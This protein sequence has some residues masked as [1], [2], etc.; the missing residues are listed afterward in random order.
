M[1][2]AGGSAIRPRSLSAAS[3]AAPPAANAQPASAAEIGQSPGPRRRPPRDSGLRE[4]EEP[5][6]PPRWS[7][8]AAPTSSAGDG[9]PRCEGGEGTARAGC[10]GGF[11]TSPR[12]RTPPDSA[13]LAP[14]P[15]QQCCLMGRGNSWTPG[16][17]RASEPGHVFLQLFMAVGEKP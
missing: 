17:T 11:R 8:R 16:C 4:E 14:V 5:E 2:G 15:A 3:L 13:S 10:P 12:R 6:P 7:R 9:E 1:S